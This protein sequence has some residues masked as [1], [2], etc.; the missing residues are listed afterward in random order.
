MSLKLVS[1]LVHAAKEIGTPMDVEHDPPRRFLGSFPLFIITAHLNPISPERGAWSAPLPPRLSS[2][3]L[4]SFR[5]ELLS[6][7]KSC[8]FDCGLRDG[9]VLG[10]DPGGRG[11]PLRGESLDILDGMMRGIDEE[12]ANE[13]QRDV[14]GNVGSGLLLALLAIK[15]LDGSAAETRCSE[16]NEHDPAMS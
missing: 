13:M 8:L 9:Q 10:S 7:S 1:V 12:L 6:Q 4:D 5:A 14:V 15:V 2:E 11:Y 3:Q 16:D